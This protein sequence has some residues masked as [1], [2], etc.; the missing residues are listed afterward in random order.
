MRVWY[1]SDM[2]GSIQ[3]IIFEAVRSTLSS[4]FLWLA[5]ELP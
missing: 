4:S 1:S 5:V 3:P 2:D